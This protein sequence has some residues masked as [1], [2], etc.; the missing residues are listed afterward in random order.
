M[1]ITS[2]LRTCA[3]AA[4]TH[5]LRRKPHISC[6]ANVACPPQNSQTPLQYITLRYNNATIQVRLVTKQLMAQ[7]VC[8]PALP[9]SSKLVDV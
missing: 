1:A 6:V 2:A 5:Q 4:C 3:A 8:T 9:C 7:E